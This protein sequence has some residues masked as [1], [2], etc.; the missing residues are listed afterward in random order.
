MET[1]AVGAI[2]LTVVSPAEEEIKLKLDSVT[3][4]HH[5]M[6]ELIAMEMTLILQLAIIRIAQLVYKC[7]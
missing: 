4:R 1:G 2:F 6:E 7:I 5:L 3:V